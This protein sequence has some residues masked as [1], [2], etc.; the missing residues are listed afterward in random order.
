[1]KDKIKQ[2]L[3]TKTKKYIAA[4]L[5]ILIAA[6]IIYI[7]IPGAKVETA[8]TR[9]ATISCNTVEQLKSCETGIS[10]EVNCASECKSYKM[11]DKINIEK[12][13]S[14]VFKVF[15]EKG[16]YTYIASEDVVF[17]NT[18]EYEQTK[19][20]KE[21]YQLQNEK[22]K[23]DLINKK[24][25]EV[26]PKI[27]KVFASTNIRAE[28]YYC[29]IKPEIWTSLTMPEKKQAFILCGEYGKLKNNNPYEDLNKM[30]I[31]TTIKSADTDEILAE[32]KTIKGVT[33]ND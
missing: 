20:E 9:V 22:I 21:K 14:E 8:F 24:L 31:K 30:Q 32:Y 19:K 1:M 11:L 29:Y 10:N 18:P 26:E 17:E 5:L 6:A 28:L 2:I 16:K 23:K 3:N 12:T 25:A 33:K 7:L 4:Y 15:N 27:K 13:N